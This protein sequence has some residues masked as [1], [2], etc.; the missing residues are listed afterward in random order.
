MIKNFLINLMTYLAMKRLLMVMSVGL[1]FNSVAQAATDGK[2]IFDKNCSVCHSVMPPPKTAPPITPL[3][4]HYH[5]KFK[6]KIEG[7]NHLAAY[8]KSPKK[9]NAID[10][11]A[12]TATESNAL[13]N[14]VQDKIHCYLPEQFKPFLAD[15]VL[16]NIL[17]KPLID[18]S[19]QICALVA[20]GGQLVLSG[21]LF[22]QA[23]SV[24]N[25]YEKYIDFNPLTQQEDWI[26]L[27]GI[28]R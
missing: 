5:Q 22:E 6:T 20:T 11:Q 3:A 24:I 1:L 15:V 8:L 4:S 9:E 25:A 26:R 27:D 19:E 21:I 7:V 28:K 10:P 17:A 18:M 13:K 23:E 12:I 2:A 16:A 14:K